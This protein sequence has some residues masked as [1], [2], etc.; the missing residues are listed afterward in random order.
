MLEV[1]KEN[2]W[3]SNYASAELQIDRD[4]VD[5]AIKN[6]WRCRSRSPYWYVDNTLQEDMD[7][8]IAAVL[9]KPYVFF[10][11]ATEMRLKQ[12]LMWMAYL[13]SI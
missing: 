2:G 10:G 4:V 11:M 12:K 6:N 8:T 3:M 9:Q 7:I 5:V 1:I 13:Q